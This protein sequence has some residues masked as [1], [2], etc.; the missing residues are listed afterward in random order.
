MALRLTTAK[1][2]FEATRRP[3]E[4]A[5]ELGRAALAKNDLPRYRELLAECASESDYQRAYK[6]RRT[7]I[8]L[9]LEKLGATSNP[10]AVAPLMMAVAQG[11]IEGLVGRDPAALGVDLHGWESSCAAV[12]EME[13]IA[14]SQPANEPA[15]RG[16]YRPLVPR[17]T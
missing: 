9:G 6:A 13:G 2:A 10:T 11:A 14:R 17:P 12:G 16:L 5:L 1:T 4:E 7:L 15:G 3:G 8:E